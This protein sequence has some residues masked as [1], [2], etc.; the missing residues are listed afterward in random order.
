M[1]RM[2]LGRILLVI[3]SLSCADSLQHIGKLRK[4]QGEHNIFG[5]EPSWLSRRSL[6]TGICAGSLLTVLK[7]SSVLAKKTVSEYLETNDIKMPP[8]SRASEFQGIDNMYFP[9]WMEG[10]WDL[11]QTLV[12][13]STPLGLKFIGGPSGS[14]EIA[15][16]S[17]EEQQKQLNKPVHLRVKFLKTKF[18][19]AEDRLYNLRSRLDAFAGR[20][21]VA[22]VKYADVGGSNRQGVLALGGSVDDPL[23]T[24]LVY[25]KGPAA[26]K[27]FMVAHDSEYLDAKKTQW[28]GYELSRAIFQLTN[29]STAPPVTTDSEAIWYLNYI[30]ES[31][32]TGKLRLAGF[33]NP[34]DRLYFDAKNR[35]VSIADYT[36]ELKRI[37]NKE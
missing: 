33:L 27:T 20:K 16:K 7:P 12:E 24:T 2:T 32:V 29:E 1:E 9:S 13:T 22:T 17:M 4:L 14:E 23:Q 8:P 30:N 5:L 28:A 15:A 6:L 19:V 37:S 3:F 31:T 26:Q 35:A 21:V 18:G 11:V 25:F 34:Q 10:E 36:I